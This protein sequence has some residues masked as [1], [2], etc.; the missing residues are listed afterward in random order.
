VYNS[1]MNKTIETVTEETLP[2]EHKEKAARLGLS[3]AAY[4]DFMR[5]LYKGVPYMPEVIVLGVR[6][7]NT[8]PRWPGQELLEI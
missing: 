2:A 4:L 6:C 5:L 1:L 7:V 8:S 3:P